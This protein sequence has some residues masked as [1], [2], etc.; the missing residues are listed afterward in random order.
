VVGTEAVEASVLGPP[1]E[2]VVRH[3]R[4]PLVTHPW[5]W[6]FTMLRD[7]ALLQLRLT[8]AALAHGLVTKDATPHNVQFVGNRPVF[9]DLGS[10][11]K[12]ER[13]EPWPGYRQFCQMYLNPLLL[14]AR[15]DVPFQ[16]WL[17]GRMEGITPGE[18]SR[19]LGPR[20]RLRPAVAV[21]VWLHGRAERRYGRSDRDLRGELSAAGFGPSVVDT[22]LRSLERFVGRLRWARGESTW[23]TYATRSHYT[24]ADLTAK[25]QVVR[26][27]TAARAGGTV[28]DLGANDGR[29]SRIAAESADLVVA[30]DS[31]ALVVDLLHRELAAGAP[32]RIVPM[33]MD[34]VDS[35]PSQGWRG[36]ERG[37]LSDRSQPDVVLALAVVHHLALSGT[38]PPAEIVDWLASLGA[39]LVVEV[40]H[41]EDPMVRRMLARKRR[42][43]FGDY[44]RETFSDALGQRMDIRSV[45]L[46]PGGTRTLLHATPRT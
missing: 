40:P 42:N 22:Q 26:R 35:S 12:L 1:W 46:L 31:D 41:R 3:E 24:D 9:I 16:P 30:V 11:E 21:H 32:S 38:V 36:V 17:R 28:W 29:F 43:L 19:L 23:S 39:E 34:L 5:E 15:R 14:Q 8:R 6:T 4:V 20:D 2:R 27:V 10:F 45:E 44:S 25:E 7:A 13:G 37:S 33:V 18:A